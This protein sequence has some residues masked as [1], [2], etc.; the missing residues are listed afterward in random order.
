[1]LH[2]TL[3][4][5]LPV[6]FSRIPDWLRQS[7][8]L[9]RT[10]ACQSRAHLRLL[11]ASL[12]S[13]ADKNVWGGHTCGANNMGF[14]KR[15]AKHWWFNQDYSS[16][17]KTSLPKLHEESLPSDSP[18]GTDLSFNILMIVFTLAGLRG[19]LP[20]HI[21]LPPSIT[22]PY[23]SFEEALKT[24][25]NQEVASRLESAIKKIPATQAE[26]ALAEVRSI[27]MEVSL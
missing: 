22:V 16:S 25:E 24:K 6:N 14:M 8:W 11:W 13:C 5:Q 23:S 27:V 26:T 10:D 7:I 2:E 18:Y 4:F 3:C 20:D 21:K 19:K 1:M 12:R 9:Y 17:R 15:E